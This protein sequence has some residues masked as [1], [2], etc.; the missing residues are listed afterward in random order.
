MSWGHDSRPLDL[1]G[2]AGRLAKLQSSFRSWDRDVFGLVRKKL[3]CLR[4]DLD[5]ERGSTL[6]RGLTPQEKNLMSELSE[7]LAREEEMERKQSRMDWLKA[8][9]RKTDFFHAKA[10][11]RGRTNRIRALKTRDGSLATH[12]SVLKQMASDFYESLFAAQDNLEPELICQH[13]P[14]KVSENIGK[15]LVRPFTE[16]EVKATLF[17]MKPGK[18]PGEDGFTA[19]FF[20]KHW[21]LLRKDVTNSVL[22]FLNGGDMP[23]EFNRTILVLIPK[24]TNP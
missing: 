19:G 24:V 17:Q 12:Q 3:K 16:E 9:D 23:K 7:M 8:G 4:K 10:K 1:E 2:M 6:Y 13:I 5:A 20:Q 22:G 11:A 21:E 14:H 15:G 18:S